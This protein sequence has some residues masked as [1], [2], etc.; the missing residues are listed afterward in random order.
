MKAGHPGPSVGCGEY[1]RNRPWFR[2]SG[3]LLPGAPNSLCVQHLEGQTKAENVAERN[4]RLAKANQSA[5]TRQFYLF[6]QLGIYED[7]PEPETTV[8]A[9]VER[10]ALP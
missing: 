7:E 10:C 8:A 2:G 1:S 9:V 6:K 3:A 4:T 5:A